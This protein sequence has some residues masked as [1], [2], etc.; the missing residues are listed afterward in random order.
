MIRFGHPLA[1]A[2][3][4]R[5]SGRE[6]GAAW[7]IPPLVLIIM[8]PVTEYLVG[9]DVYIR[10]TLLVAPALTAI[11]A[12]PLITAGMSALALVSVV[13]AGFVPP[14]VSMH[15]F[16]TEVV[17]Q[18]VVS[19][20]LVLFCH[21]RDTRELE[22][23]RIRDV[24]YQA[25]RVVLRP[26]PAR[27]G[28]LSIGSA[29]RAVQAHVHVGGDLY[30]VARTSSSTRLVIGDVKGHGLDSI[31]DTATLLGAFR[32]MAHREPSLPDLL[33]YLDGA[34]RWSLEELGGT[35]STERFVTVLVAEIPDEEPVVHLINCGHP[36]PLRLRGDTVTPLAVPDPAPPLGLAL[37]PSVR[38]T[39]TTF[40]FTPGDML[41]LYTDGV[42][43]T[44]DDEGRFYPLA[45]RVA[46]WARE[47]PS[48]LVRDLTDDLLA[49]AGGTI[50]DDMALIAAA[51]EC[52]PA[53][54]GTNPSRHGP[55]TMARPT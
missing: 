22:L 42:T 50:R 33:D 55:R 46:A 6:A 43:E 14:A 49:Y 24:S 21:L 30:A 51:R 13:V 28:P 44:R 12:G 32:A 20:V 53:P 11:V 16:V 4:R 41:L 15:N 39:H 52:A 26:L 48:D 38:Y 19:G 35:E 45:E 54:T 17:T 18:I 40:P 31:S 47:P 25:Q 34:T 9:P 36:P 7:L 23:M 3:A 27:A 5:V 37:T 10:Q 2:P 29:Y 1:L 8:I